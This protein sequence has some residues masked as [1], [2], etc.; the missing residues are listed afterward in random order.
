M[1]VSVFD[2][3]DHCCG[4]PGRSSPELAQSL[5]FATD[6]SRSSKLI[7]NLHGGYE[8]RGIHDGRPAYDWQNVALLPRP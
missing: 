1:S 7:T 5:R 8:E 4:H 3:C 2:I 6:A